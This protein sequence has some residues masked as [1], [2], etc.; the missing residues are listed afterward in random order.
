MSEENI[1][2]VVRSIDAYNADDLDAQM[3]TY[4]PTAVAITHVNAETRLP[5]FD[6]RTEGRAAMRRFVAQTRELWRGRYE[7]VRRPGSR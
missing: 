1:E 5:D 6:H 3:A 7:P 2:V 4:L